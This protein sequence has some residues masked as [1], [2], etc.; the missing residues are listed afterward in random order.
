MAMLLGIRLGPRDQ[1][2][3]DIPFVSDNPM[4]RRSDRHHANGPSE[5]VRG[6]ARFRNVVVIRPSGGEM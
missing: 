5:S 1:R 4:I 3:T 6:S 2:W